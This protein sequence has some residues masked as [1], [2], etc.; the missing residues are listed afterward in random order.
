MDVSLVPFLCAKEMNRNLL[1]L[2]E[3]ENIRHIAS[4]IDDVHHALTTYWAFLWFPLHI[5]YSWSLI[6]HFAFSFTLPFTSSASDL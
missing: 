5:N 1:L 6:Y 2:F 3:K 4:T